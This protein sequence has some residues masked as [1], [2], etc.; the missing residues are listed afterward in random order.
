MPDGAPSGTFPVASY[1]R[2]RVRF[3]TCG[4]VDDGKSTLIGRLMHDSGAIF[5]D[6]LAEASRASGGVSLDFSFLVD[7]LK[8]ERE[9]GIT[10]D[11]AYRYFMTTRRAFR[12]ADAPGHEQYTRNQAAAA[13]Q[14]DLA[15]LVVSSIEGVRTQTRRHLAIARLFGVSDV[16]VAISKMDLIA[17][18]A[19]RFEELSREVSGVCRDLGLTVRGLVPVAARDGDFVVR[20]GA[21]APWYDGPTV[22]A[23]LESFDVPSPSGDG[24]ILPVQHVARLDGGGRL[25]LGE[26]AS[27][28]LDIGMEVAAERGQTARVSEL[29]VSGAPATSAGPGDAV[30]LRLYPE[31][32]V[33]RGAVLSS[34]DSAISKAS[35]V[36]ARIV[37][38]GD[39]ALQVGRIYD[40][41]VGAA[42]CPATVTRVAGIVDLDG[43]H[44][45]LLERPVVAND[46][47]VGVVTFQGGI[48]CLPFAVSRDLGA[49]ILVE[50]G[51]QRTV[52]AG[53]VL[54][55]DQL[56]DVTPWQVLEVT[57][58]ARAQ[59][60]GQAAAVVWLTGLSGSG[61]STIAG[62]L[63]KR[64]HA[65]GRHGTVLD[66]DN[67]RQGLNADLGFS[68]ADRTENVRRVA[69]VA[70]L[71]ANAGL[72]VIVSLISPFAADRERAREIVGSG[73]F[74][75]V[76]VDASLETCAER[77]PKGHY[78]RAR[79]GTIKQFTGLQSSYEPPLR[80]DLRLDTEGQSP[81]ASVEAILAMLAQAT[82]GPDRA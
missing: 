20:R 72:I 58:D 52:A 22:L 25:I 66:G 45:E 60:L 61:K 8:A 3:M 14:T 32:D 37:W 79:Q 82:R 70:G 78:R 40:C 19:E 4:S 62:L 74:F 50:R 68:D 34:G 46:I 42:R 73:R 56:T 9:Q 81:E 63:D 53:V 12:I 13:S 23:L 30:A 2:P 65:M 7:G 16:I 21:Q 29:W 57:P 80:P 71:M 77:D 39:T 24:I 17:W 44:L 49:F 54:D 5:E 15:L 36:T 33:G 69:H 27:G 38:F 6:H 26:V 55:I 35:R 11:V 59:A 18:S 75:E 31:R 28:Y 76:F 10:I 47:A 48:Q 41:L 43:L 64:L 67:L 1:A 51:T